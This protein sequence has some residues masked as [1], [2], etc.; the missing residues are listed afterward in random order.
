[1][2]KLLFAG[3]CAAFAAAVAQEATVTGTYAEASA[4]S[5][6]VQVSATVPVA[7]A[8]ETYSD[9][10]ELE[11]AAPVAAAEETYGDEEE[12]EE[13]S[14]AP[15]P[16]V[17]V[18]PAPA[19]P[20]AVLAD[21]MNKTVSTH[22]NAPTASSI[23]QKDIEDYCREAKITLGTVTPKGA[24]YLAH[25][26]PVLAK[27]GSPN[28]VRSR[29]LAFAKAYQNALA[30]YVIG[31]VGET[32]TETLVTYFDDD[33]SDRLEPAT[34]I[35]GTQERIKEKV[36]QL[37]EAQLDKGLRELGVT[38]AGSITEVR[39]LAR[40][41][42]LSKSIKTAAGA[43]SGVV[44]VQTFEGWNESPDAS[45]Q[46]YAVGVIVRGGRDTEAVANALRAKEKPALQKPE[47]AISVA[48]A[49]PSDEE[50]VSQFGVRM[51]FD[52]NGTPALLSFGQF[53]SGYTGDDPVRQ[54]R[55]AKMALMQAETI[56]D[57]QLTT[58][59]NSRIEVSRESNYGEEEYKNA[60]FR[61]DSLTGKGEE[62]E[63]EARYI[64][65]ILETS[66]VKGAD[67]MIGRSTVCK[68][69]VTHPVN[70]RKIAVCVKL[71]SFDQLKEMQRL[72]NGP[73]EEKTPVAKPVVPQAP[74]KPAPRAVPAG[75]R[76]GRSYDF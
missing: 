67:T 71:W 64:S 32:A 57:D 27:A 10:E 3:T 58:F 2:K 1:M 51:F 44:P 7:V 4:Q 45:V 42:I 35:A 63:A 17:A 24:K 19:E 54:E 70:G 33:S 59:I 50:L 26:E 43:A 56:A 73:E 29:S 22:A 14:P 53:G 34:T 16:A 74:A 13:V 9:E 15:A 49:M 31:K 28:F 76:R 6:V 60:V 40:N 66:R 46:L 18:A 25:V 8:E 52:E 12:I 65:T 38:P 36:D 61:S 68:K 11:A 55:A 47:L 72:V 48:D 23:V 30:E 69:I 21:E 20:A 41:I 62:V 37:T 39:A 75:K 5:S